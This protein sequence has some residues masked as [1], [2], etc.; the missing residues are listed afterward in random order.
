MC[1]SLRGVGSSVRDV[2]QSLERRHSRL[3]ICSRHSSLHAHAPRAKA[4]TAAVLDA[5]NAVRVRL[6]TDQTASGPPVIPVTTTEETV[7]GAD[8]MRYRRAAQMAAQISPSVYSAQAATTS[9]SSPLKTLPQHEGTSASPAAN[10]FLIFE[11]RT[12]TVTKGSGSGFGQD[13]RRATY[14][15]EGSKNPNPTAQRPQTVLFPLPV[16]SPV[17]SFINC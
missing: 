16:R 2:L 11:P 14:N 15:K 3:T 6:P 7:V 17:H 13:T 8:R 4:Q 12:P 10:S 1:C 5:R 9:S